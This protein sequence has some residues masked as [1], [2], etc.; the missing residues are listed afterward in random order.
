MHNVFL[1]HDDI[2]DGDKK[3]RN[4]DTL[5]VRFGLPNAINVGD[6]LLAKAYSILIKSPVREATLKELIDVFTTTYLIT[7]RGQALD[8]NLRA[9]ADLTQERY[10]EIVSLKTARYLAYNLVGGAIVA[11][12]DQGIIDRL[13]EVGEALGPAFQIQDD[14]LDLT[15]GKGRGGEIGCDIREGKPTIFL[16]FVLEQGIDNSDT[17]KLLDIP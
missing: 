3:R 6:F 8:I 4:R 14:L 12:T 16:A 1:L 17:K 5:W 2:E 7:T 15:K 10:F 11:G 9:S 13:W